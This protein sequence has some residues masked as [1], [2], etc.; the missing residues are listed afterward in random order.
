MKCFVTALLASVL[1]F[2]ATGC[3]DTR[4]DDT[5]KGEKQ[6]RIDATRGG[7][8]RLYSANTRRPIAR[9]SSDFMSRCG[10]ARPPRSSSRGAG[11]V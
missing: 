4:N 2:L 5:G 11:Q 8:G 3:H 6:E 1:L 7:T 10:N 9:G